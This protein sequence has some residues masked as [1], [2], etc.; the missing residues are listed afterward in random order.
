MTT[1]DFMMGAAR[2]AS[3]VIGLA[4]VLITLLS[5]IKAFVLPRGVRVWL[6]RF[7]FQLVR[8]VFSFKLRR[9]DFEQREQIMALY[10]PLA[11]VLMP[12]FLLSSVLIGYMFLFWAL[13][14]APP[15]SLSTLSA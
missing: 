10:A 9:A 13:E 12:V 15:Q 11:L 7:V 14:P 6:V 2:V 1:M 8:A 3:A 5:A 4:I